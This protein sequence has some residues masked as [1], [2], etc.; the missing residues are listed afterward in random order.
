M[1]KLLFRI[2]FVVL[3]VILSL[4]IYLSSLQGR[5]A[6]LYT[7]GPT[8]EKLEFPKTFYWGAS[9]AG[10]QAET[11]QA[12]DWAEFEKDAF[13]HQ[14]FEAGKEMETTKPGHIR[15]YGNWS[16]QVR[17]DKSGFDKM[18]A[19]DFA[20]SAQ[21]GLNGFRNSIEWAR[22]FPRADMT[23]PDPN[24]I[25][26]YKDM[27][28]E[29]KKHHITPF[30]TLFHYVA[31]AWFF[32]PDA[33]GKKGWERADA[34]QHWQ[35]FVEAVANN[36]IP[37][38]EQWCTLNEPMVYV[39]SGY[40]DGLYPPLEH[41]KDLEA[42]AGVVEGLL[43]AHALAYQ[44]LHRVAAER[45]VTVNVGITQAMEAFEPLRN[46]AP[47]DRLLTNLVA[48]AWNWD[49]LDAIQ[50]GRLKMA[51]TS[52]DHVIAGLQG[53]QDYV[54][55]NYYMRVFVKSDLFD[56]ANPIIM[57][58][59]P[60]DPKAIVNDMGW[61]F[62]PHG[63]Y[64]ILTESYHRYQKPVFVLENGTADQKLD[65]VERQR[66]IVSH[67]R[68]VWLAI[69][70]GGAD[71]RSYMQWS[72]FDNFE[73]VNGFD[74]KFGLEAVDYEHDFNRIPRKSAGLYS[75]IAHANGVTAEMMKKY[76]IQ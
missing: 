1:M 63:F 17:R 70:H 68:E 34:M 73:W 23:E 65:D 72:L 12:S 44:T 20:T 75:E 41:R 58:R 42:T 11:M 18:Y 7:H 19:Q 59:D 64:N 46:L 76:G 54:G 53:T 50:S 62:Y 47:L 32:Q 38:V 55:V 43:K 56:P 25:A 40:I 16:E 52:V 69:H 71:V 37:D 28:A 8:A 24:A 33:T 30:M 31:P 15:N 29:M 66:Y 61:Q 21:M 4:A 48:Q 74:A 45:H 51:N 5:G 14:R 10:E 2:V 26:Y 9:I 36:F 13:L 3:L 27:I 22:L 57:L 39:Y 6:S 49:F 67:V 35:R 60:D